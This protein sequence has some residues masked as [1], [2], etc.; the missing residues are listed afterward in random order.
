[1]QNGLICT[2]LKPSLF[3]RLAS[4]FLLFV[5]KKE[6]KENHAPLPLISFGLSAASAW[7]LRNSRFQR[8]N[9]PR[10]LASAAQA[11]G[12]ARELENHTTTLVIP[13]KRSAIRNSVTLKTD[14]FD[15]LRAN[16]HTVLMA[17]DFVGWVSVA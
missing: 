13:C 6:T 17:L 9:R 1:M 4:F 8:S 3:A 2:P 11:E 10:H 16:I 5:Q 15:A 14:L 7:R 12:A